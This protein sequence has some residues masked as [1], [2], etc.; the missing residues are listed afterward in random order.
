[1]VLEE[2]CFSLQ[3]ALNLQMSYWDVC[4]DPWVGYFALVFLSFQS[5][6]TP[7]G[8]CDLIMFWLGRISTVLLLGHSFPQ[9]TF[10]PLFKVFGV[11]RFL[12][13]PRGFCTWIFSLAFA[14]WSL[15]DSPLALIVV[16]GGMRIEG[17]CWF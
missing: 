16:V 11:W 12:T 7:G 2:V 3:Q 13:R 8:V 10:L 14:V 4:V 9:T 5:C 15:L 1:V 6:C 17:E